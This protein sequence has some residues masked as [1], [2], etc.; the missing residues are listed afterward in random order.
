MCVV[1]YIMQSYAQWNA[2][3]RDGRTREGLT[4]SPRVPSRA[5]S[6]VASIRSTMSVGS[7]EVRLNNMEVRLAALADQSSHQAGLLERQSA[8]LEALLA[9]LNG[10]S[11]KGESSKP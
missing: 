8:L 11:T 4:S 3:R 1:S 6:D 2:Q 9:K 10:Q 5:S 7:I